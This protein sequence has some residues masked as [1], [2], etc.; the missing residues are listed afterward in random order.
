MPRHQLR[1]KNFRPSVIAAA[2]QLFA[3][4]PWAIEDDEEIL[5]V[6]QNFIDAVSLAYRVS[7]AK[8][9]I[10]GGT[11]R[12]ATYLDAEFDTPDAVSDSDEM[13]LV[14]PPRIVIG[15]FA[16]ITLF[17]Q[18]RQH[19]LAQGVASVSGYAD[20]VGW[21]CSLFYKAK[22]KMFRARAREGR[23]QHVTARD[24]FSAESWQ[25]LSDAVLTVGNRLIGSP[26]DWSRALGV[27]VASTHDTTAR[28]GLTDLP[29]ELEFDLS[30]EELEAALSD[31][32][33]TVDFLVARETEEDAAEEPSAPVHPEVDLDSAN[34]DTLRQLAAAVDLP[35]RGSMNAPELREALRDRMTR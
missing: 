35:G 1:F 11:R 29:D 6:G 32:S 5:L 20:P 15:R 31:D 16:I 9:V 13:I 33:P 34:R 24:T 3:A 26:E 8:L 30:D 18:T 12:D 2:D 25:K 27:T 22:P 10:T 21:G 23:M 28:A 14:N 17:I 19:L 4:R 7:S